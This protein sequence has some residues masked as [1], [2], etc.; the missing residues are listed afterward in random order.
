[1]TWLAHVKS[2]M[3]R[4]AG[5]KASMGKKWF[6]HVLKTAKHTYK[7]KKGRR[8]GADD[9]QPAAPSSGDEMRMG[10]PEGPV[11]SEP[12]EEGGRRRGRGSKK[13]RR[14]RKH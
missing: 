11:V 6:R 5:K 7:G 2:T 13:T 3:K 8:G 14:V 1:M 4:E 9:V 12:K 10:G